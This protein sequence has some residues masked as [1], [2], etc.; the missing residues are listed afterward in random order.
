M[1]S[2]GSAAVAGL[3]LPAGISHDT[4]DTCSLHLD[5]FMA[6]LRV[7]SAKDVGCKLVGSDKLPA[8]FSGLSSKVLWKSVANIQLPSVLNII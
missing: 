8:T 7:L 5:L 6:V 2:E 3:V 4:G 1:N